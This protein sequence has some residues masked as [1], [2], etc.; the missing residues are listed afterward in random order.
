LDSVRVELGMANNSINQTRIELIKG[1]IANLARRAEVQIPEVKIKNVTLGIAHANIKDEIEIS[2]ELITKW[3][4]GF[5]TNSDIE[6]VLAHELG[7]IIDGKKGFKKWF[8]LG[9]AT[10]CIYVM[11]ILPI[12]F[13]LRDIFLIQICA[14][15]IWAFFLPVLFKWLQNRSELRADK[16][17]LELTTKENFAHYVVNRLRGKHQPLNPLK[18]WQIY[19]SL[20]SHPGLSER[21]SLL[22]NEVDDI[23]VKLKE[24][25][26]QQ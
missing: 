22:E 20:A 9:L 19:Y 18:I 23:E 13:L 14:F 10:L 11:S 26:S 1:I 2:P 17:A 4:S 21:L 6:V 15:I 3:E 16:Y 5:Y 12:I 25:A 24:P 8:Y 7:H